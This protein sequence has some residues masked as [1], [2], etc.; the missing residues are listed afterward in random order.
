[1]AHPNGSQ[2]D[3]HSCEEGIGSRRLH[4]THPKFSSGCEM[5][6]AA[7]ICHCCCSARSDVHCYL[8]LLPLTEQLFISC[9][10]VS[11]CRLS[12]LLHTDFVDLHACLC[13]GLV[14]F[15][16]LQVHRMSSLH[17]KIGRSVTP[18]CEVFMQDCVKSHMV[19]LKPFV[20]QATARGVWGAVG[21]HGAWQQGWYQGSTPTSP[22]LLTS[23]YS[24]WQTTAAGYRLGKDFVA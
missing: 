14:V 18:V 13:A 15:S 6:I 8:L 2:H 9:C 21:Q 20:Q 24:S 5:R 19:C 17:H 23:D 10:C 11:Q 4:R 16:K 3:I 1:M 12:A 7:P 22:S